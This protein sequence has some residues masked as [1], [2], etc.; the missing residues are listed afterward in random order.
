MPVLHVWCVVYTYVYT[1]CRWSHQI[2]HQFYPI[3]T[4]LHNIWNCECAAQYRV[5]CSVLIPRFSCEP[6]VRVL[7]FDVHS[8]VKSTVV[9]T[10][11]NV[12][13][14]SRSFTFTNYW[15]VLHVVLD[16]EL[17]AHM[18]NWISNGLNYFRFEHRCAWISLFVYGGTYVGNAYHVFVWW[19]GCASTHMTCEA[20]T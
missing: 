18:S 4:S 6:R 19:G 15:F 2:A 5:N 16:C 12:E 17:N 9:N 8:R 3:H 1:I 14:H 13:L 7:D 11:F 20:D 10:V